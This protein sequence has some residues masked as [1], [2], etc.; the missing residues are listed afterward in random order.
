MDAILLD[1]TLAHFKIFC[2]IAVRIGSLL[3]L[4]PIFSSRALPMQIK[5]ATTLVMAL[6]FTPVVP[7]SPDDFPTNPWQFGLLVVTELFVGMSLALIIRLILAGIQMAGQM[8]GFQMGFSVANVVDPQSGAQSVIIAQ[9]A[10]LITLMIFLAVDG[11]HLFL[12]TIYESFFLLPPGHLSLGDPLYELVMDTGQD[13]FVLSIKLM[14][15]VMAILFLSQVALGILAKLVPQINMLIVSF[16][17]NIGLG[18][19]FLG[20]TLQVFWPVLAKSL[21]RGLRLLPVALQLMAK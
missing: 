4:M 8:V 14:A 21:D 16:S 12:R 11:H 7:F 20:L 19:F 3:F 10:Y 2:L 6:L 1:W 18:L 17:L 9:V 5:A 15:P 13:M